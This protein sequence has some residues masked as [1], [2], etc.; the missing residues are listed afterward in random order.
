MSTQQSHFSSAQVEARMRDDNTYNFYSTHPLK[1]C[2]CFIRIDLAIE[3][4]HVKPEDRPIMATSLTEWWH[5]QLVL[6]M[7][8]FALL[9]DRQTMCPWLITEESLPTSTLTPRMECGRLKSSSVTTTSHNTLVNPDSNT[10]RLLRRANTKNFDQKLTRLSKM[11]FC[12]WILWI[13]T[14]HSSHVT[15]PWPAYSNNV[16]KQSSAELNVEENRYMARSRP[17]KSNA[18]RHKSRSRRCTENGLLQLPKRG[19]SCVPTV[20]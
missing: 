3:I 17:P 18:Y 8:K 14:S 1:T 6:T 16:A 9:T 13:T 11:S 5:W 10:C 4:G 12:T 19:I 15:R 20:F 7:P 2:G